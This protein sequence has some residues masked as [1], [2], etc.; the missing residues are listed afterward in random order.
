MEPGT[1]RELTVMVEERFRSIE[2]ALSL[3]A[4]EY[5]RRLEDLNHAHELA[6]ARNDE[7]VSKDEFKGYVEAQDKKAEAL[8][9][10]RTGSSDALRSAVIAIISAIVVAG[11][12]IV[13]LVVATR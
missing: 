8:V 9:L 11:G 12:V 10:A 4:I 5:E 3:Q 7:F 13:S 6:Q 1:L 2:A